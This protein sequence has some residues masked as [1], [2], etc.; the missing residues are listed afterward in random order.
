VAP[1]SSSPS[2]VSSLCSFRCRYVFSSAP[3]HT[4]LDPQ[5]VSDTFC[6]PSSL[7]YNRKTLSG[8]TIFQQKFKSAL[9]TLLFKMCAIFL[10][11]LGDYEGAR[12]NMEIS[13]ALSVFSQFFFSWQ[14]SLKEGS[15]MINYILKQ[16][17]KRRIRN[18]LGHWQLHAFVGQAGSLY[19]S[20]LLW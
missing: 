6:L 19:L 9:C 4:L 12:A 7:K 11:S 15:S 14:N 3:S 8:H 20:S 16:A 13:C 10:Y 17:L 5:T 2:S 18:R 1:G